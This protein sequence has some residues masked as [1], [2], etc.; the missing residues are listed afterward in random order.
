MFVFHQNWTAVWPL[1][2]L[3]IEKTKQSGSSVLVRL[4]IKRFVPSTFL[5]Q[6]KALSG[7]ELFN[8]FNNASV[9]L[10]LSAQSHSL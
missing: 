8:Y 10:S 9:N 4:Q 3:V 5:F 2:L 6:R 1:K 7:L